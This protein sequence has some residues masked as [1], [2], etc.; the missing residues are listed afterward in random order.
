M[1]DVAGCLIEMPIFA[2]FFISFSLYSKRGALRQHTCVEN[3]INRL[4]EFREA[5]NE[6]HRSGLLVNFLEINNNRLIYINQGC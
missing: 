1:Q 2:I 3:D 5:K 6:P 4:M